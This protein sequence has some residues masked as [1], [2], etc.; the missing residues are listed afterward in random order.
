M[1]I[2]STVAQPGEPHEAARPV[3]IA[4]KAAGHRLLLDRVAR[5]AVTLGGV[6]IIA[7][8]LAIL[9]VIVVQV[10]PLFTPPT[11]TPLAG[12]RIPLN[13]PPLAL[14]VDEYREIA[15]LVT[16]DGMVFAPLTGDAPARKA[17]LPDLGAAK[18]TTA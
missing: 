12:T 2:R 9:F 16:P 7:S 1:S 10:Y 5:W 14:G 11:A 13:A 17:P 3:P 4:W 8:I 6:T 15:Y 18:T